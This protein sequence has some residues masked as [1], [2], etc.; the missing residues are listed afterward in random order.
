M[1]GI[2]C[3]G[4]PMKNW[5]FVIPDGVA[6]AAAAAA[7]GS[8]SSDMQQQ[9]QQ[10]QQQETAE[11]GGRG[12]AAAVAWLNRTNLRAGNLRSVATPSAAACAQLCETMAAC[13]AWVFAAGRNLCFLKNP[14]FC[15]N[16]A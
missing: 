10:Q 7:D 8:K 2:E 5:L 14:D 16:P 3:K 4:K 12:A 13:K 9:Q 15:V 1:V 11:G 6:A